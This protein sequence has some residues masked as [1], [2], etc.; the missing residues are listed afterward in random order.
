MPW[1]WT[2]DVAHVLVANGTLE[3]VEA[4]EMITFPVA[5]RSERERRAWARVIRSDA[6][7][8]GAEQG[9]FG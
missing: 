4:A 2:D 8:D 1:Y 5:H 3:A 6:G 7:V 9:G